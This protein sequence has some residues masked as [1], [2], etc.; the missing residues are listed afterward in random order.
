MKY[1]CCY[2]FY[3]YVSQESVLSL[4]S[5]FFS[6]LTVKH[7]YRRLVGT[8][9]CCH[10]IHKAV[11]LL[12]ELLESIQFHALTEIPALTISIITTTFDVCLTGRFF[13]DSATDRYVGGI[14]FSGGPSVS[15][16][17]RRL[18]WVKVAARSDAAETSAS[19]YGRRS[20]ILF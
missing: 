13:Y 11:H 9:I 15:A 19:A 20:I 18:E 16:C 2:I 14:M 5:S 12:A 1:V 10:R 17:V 6:C 7:T 4:F 8:D 3:D